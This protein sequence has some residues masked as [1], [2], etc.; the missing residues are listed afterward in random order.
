MKKAT[1][2]NEA[3]AADAAQQIAVREAYITGRPPRILPLPLD[4]YGKEGYEALAKLRS[5]LS[6]PTDQEVPEF[7]LTMLCSPNFFRV[8]LEMSLYVLR[9][10]LP[11][12]DRELAVLRLAWLSEAPFVWGEHVAVAKDLAGITEDEIERVI[13]GATAEGWSE[14]DRAILRAVE[15]LLDNAMISDETW[16]V[17]KRKFNEKQLLEFPFLIGFYNAVAYLQNSLRIRIIPGHEGLSA[18]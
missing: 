10:A 2:F 6:Q 1:P 7:L 4:E 16:A 11:V 18:R 3:N 14:H 5:A 9:C 13:K 15:E 17:L 12:R 8:F